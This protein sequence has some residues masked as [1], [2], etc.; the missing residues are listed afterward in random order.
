M[1]INLI[2]MYDKNKEKNYY[3]RMNERLKKIRKGKI[4]KI[5][6][7]KYFITHKIKIKTNM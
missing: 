2:V 5:K 3:D 7:I 4:W 6:K 1:L